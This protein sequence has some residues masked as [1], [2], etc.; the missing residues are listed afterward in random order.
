MTPLRAERYSGALKDKFTFFAKTAEDS[1]VGSAT[2]TAPSLDY[3]QESLPKLREW[4]GSENYCMSSHV[5]ETNLTNFWPRWDHCDNNAAKKPLH[6]AL[7]C[8][9]LLR[10][11]AK[12]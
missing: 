10:S 12:K 1:D 5:D 3:H 6:T 8:A 2:M 11:K 7:L 4:T 9:L